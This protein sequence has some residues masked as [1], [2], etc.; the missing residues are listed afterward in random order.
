MLLLVVM[1]AVDFFIF[2]FL[3]YS[4]SHLVLM[5]AKKKNLQQVR[6]KIKAVGVGGSGGDR[7][8]FSEEE[9]K[10]ENGAQIN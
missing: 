10:K 7:M 8:S 5:P 2:H 3:F 9:R 4:K 6:W 1:K